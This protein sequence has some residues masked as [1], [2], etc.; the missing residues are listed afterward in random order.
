LQ[1]NELGKTGI[2][3]SRLCFGSLT[4]SPLQKNM[5]LQ[6]G[7][8]VIEK[9]IEL[10]VNFI[11]TADLYDTYPYIKEIIKRHPEIVICSK[12]YAYDRKTAE[13]TLT[14]ALKGIRRD[15]I[16][17][18]ML[19][20]Q[21]SI[22][23]FRGH[24]DAVSYFLEMKEKGYIRAIGISTHMV[25][26]VR[27]AWNVKEFEVIHPIINYSGI[28]ILDGTRQQ[29]ETALQEARKGGKGIFAMKPLGGGHLVSCKEKALEYILSL[30][31]L[32][33][34]AIGMQNV[35]EVIYNVNY[36]SGLPIDMNIRKE[37]EAQKR[38]LMVHDWC[39]GCGSCVSSCRAG[40]LY[41]YNNKVHVR[42]DKCFLCGYC[43]A[44]CPLFCLKV[45]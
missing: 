13:A 43:A 22:H 27:D 4:I 23:T 33:S 25:G 9:A 20:E 31:Y 40:A 1:Y 36:F 44:K 41:L 7:V 32:D 8:K 3:V 2:S 29:M 38:S 21:E 45:I 30:P 12:S 5:T 14:K 19:H 6:E 18:F 15:Y 39:E 34:I 28:G 26:C 37:L 16:D 42:T 17:V 10:G 35:A 24:W 11:D